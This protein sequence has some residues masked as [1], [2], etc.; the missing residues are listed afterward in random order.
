MTAKS[1]AESAGLTEPMLS[2]ILNGKR[3][4][5]LPTLRKIADA[6]HVNIA[7]LFAEN[8]TANKLIAFLHYRGQGHTP[9]TLQEIMAIL[10]DWDE[11]LFHKECHLHDFQNLRVKYADNQEVQHLMD[12]LCAIFN[13]AKD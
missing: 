4:P 8:V 7:E 5:S 9:T 12:A 3:N 2:D 11:E 1:V 13:C 10:K 6:L